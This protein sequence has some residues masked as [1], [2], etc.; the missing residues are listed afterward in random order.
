M[1]ET[2]IGFRKVTAMNGIAYRTAGDH[3][4]ITHTSAATAIPFASQP[5]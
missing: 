5:R 4:K 3:R 2:E 1:I